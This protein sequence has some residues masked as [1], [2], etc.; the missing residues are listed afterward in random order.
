MRYKDCVNHHL[1]AISVSSASKHHQQAD[2]SSKEREQKLAFSNRE[3]TGNAVS[4]SSTQGIGSV[5]DCVSPPVIM[6]P[7]MLIKLLVKS[8]KG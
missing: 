6:L 8:K 1:S 3:F 2:E 7:L 4:Q 5:F